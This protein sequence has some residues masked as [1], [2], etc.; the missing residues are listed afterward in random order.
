MMSKAGGVLEYWLLRERGAVGARE[1]DSLV[2]LSVG[3]S[4]DTTLIILQD[5]V[6]Q[7]SPDHDAEGN[8][9]NHNVS[10]VDES[11]LGSGGGGLNAD[12]IGA[13]VESKAAVSDDQ[14][15]KRSENTVYR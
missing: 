11:L 5:I 9:V 15:A 2:H 8:P 7:I 12:G 13:R 1:S 3:G 4:I 14:Q 6:I 10:L